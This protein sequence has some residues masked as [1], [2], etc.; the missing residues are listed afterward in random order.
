MDD[1]FDLTGKM[2][3]AMPG[4]GD[5][6]FEHSVILLCAHSDDGAMGLIVNK[7]SKDLT[8]AGLL[9]HLDIK[10]SAQV[11]DIRVHFGGPVD[12]G[13]GFILHSGEY[14]QSES[15]LRISDTM[16]MTATIDVLEDIALGIGPKQ[17]LM[18]MGYAG[19]AGGQLEAEI[20]ANG[21]LFGDVDEDLIFRADAATKWS[22]A[23]KSMGIDPLLLSAEAGH[24]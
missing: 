22:D 24:A 16:A 2:L 6:R 7:P 14:A 10:P 8:F 3:I 20:S 11:R 18:A 23:I 17:T 15:T 5:P 9:E 19:W 21:W 13:R 12:H 4:M 1:S